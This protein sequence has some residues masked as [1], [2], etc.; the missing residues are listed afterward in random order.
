MS[1]EADDPRAR[2]REDPSATTLTVQGTE[3][4]KLGYGTWQVNRP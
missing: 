3:V 1:A 2:H 4:P